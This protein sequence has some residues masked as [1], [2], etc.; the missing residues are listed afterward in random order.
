MDKDKMKIKLNL[1]TIDVLSTC[2][3]GGDDLAVCISPRNHKVDI[4]YI[5]LYLIHMKVFYGYLNIRKV[6]MLK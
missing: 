5:K 4:V 1:F 3:S 6:M 2:H